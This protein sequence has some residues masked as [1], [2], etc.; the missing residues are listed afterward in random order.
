VCIVCWQ[1]QVVHRP[2]S[3][4]TERSVICEQFK[5]CLYTVC[6]IFI[7]IFCPLDTATLCVLENTKVEVVWHHSKS[8]IYGCSVFCLIR[9]Q[10]TVCQIG[11]LSLER[12]NNRDL[13]IGNFCSNR[14]T[15]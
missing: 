10:V 13:R 6:C 1:A 12:L 15:N 9:R 8:L 7:G 2:Y 4:P 3:A 5:L 11:Q 14:I